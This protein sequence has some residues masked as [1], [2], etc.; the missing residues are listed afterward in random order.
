MSGLTIRY[1]PGARYGRA[2]IEMGESRA[3]NEVVPTALKVTQLYSGDTSHIMHGMGGLDCK[4]V[5][6]I[7]RTLGHS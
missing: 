7:R 6:K 1:A 3:A 4:N 5:F 2:E